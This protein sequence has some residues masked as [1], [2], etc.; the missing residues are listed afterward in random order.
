MI[1]IFTEFVDARFVFRN[2]R[3]PIQHFSSYILPLDTPVRPRR[4]KCRN[5]F[6]E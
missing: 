4:E 3:L 2:A 6:A 1:I 5:K